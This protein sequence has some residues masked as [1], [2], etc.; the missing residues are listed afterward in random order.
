MDA[1]PFPPEVDEREEQSGQPDDEQQVDPWD[2]SRPPELIKGFAEEP[3]H[4]RENPPRR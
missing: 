1:G 4:V 3:L 2:A